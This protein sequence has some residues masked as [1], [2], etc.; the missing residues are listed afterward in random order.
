MSQEQM[1]EGRWLESIVYGE[2]KRNGKPVNGANHYQC[3]CGCGMWAVARP[4][5]DVTLP[6]QS[7][8]QRKKNKPCNTKQC[9]HF[10]GKAID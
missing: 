1:R 3:G 9:L 8:C 4:E 5:V 6:K 2:A 10:N 7:K